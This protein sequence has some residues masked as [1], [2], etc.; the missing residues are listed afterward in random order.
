MSLDSIRGRSHEVKISPPAPSSK[1][2]LVGRQPSL[3]STP[4]NANSAAKVREQLRRNSLSI[5][6]HPFFFS[7]CPSLLS[8]PSFG[9][10]K[11]NNRGKDVLSRLTGCWTCNSQTPRNEGLKLTCAP[12]VRKDAKMR[13]KPHNGAK[14]KVQ[15]PSGIWANN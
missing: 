13:Y 2:A 7:P 5:T 10:L 4:F 15:N 3:V 6:A 12:F 11:Q 8:F 9:G 14:A 1:R